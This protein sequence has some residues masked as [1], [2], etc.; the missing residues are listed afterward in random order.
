MGFPVT[1]A[2]L[3]AIRSGYVSHAQVDIYYQ[4]NYISTAP[5]TDGSVTVDRTSNTRR[6]CQLTIGDPTFV[7]LYASST[8]APYGAELHIY[9]GLK[10]PSGTVE[11]CPLGVFQIEDVSWDDATGAL[12]QVTGY[13][14]GKA[15]ERAA[16]KVASDRAGQSAISAISS[17][18][19]EVLPTATVTVDQSLVDYTLPGGTIASGSRW[20]CVNAWANAM[21]AEVFFD[22]F[23]NAVVQTIPVVDSS[24]T[25][26]SVYWTVD[27][28]PNG[29]L[30]GA[31]RKVSRGGVYNFVVATGSNTTGNGDPPIGFAAD[32][33]QNSPT[34]WGPTSN[35]P[36]GLALGAFGDVVYQYTNN[37]LTTADQCAT[38]AR[39]QLKQ[40]LGLAKS[41]DFTCA[42]HPGLQEGDIIKV[43]YTSG[44]TEYHLVDRLNIPLVTGKFSGSTR[45]T[46]GQL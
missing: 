9:Q 31:P 21:G 22:V 19:T 26:D 14:R 28:G 6:S 32:T 20:D 18:I 35:I 45:S 30:V 15:I 23:G 44:K 37:N 34:Y 46:I 13:D 38:A 17:A 1:D 41:L 5:I 10:Y 3:S 25:D 33:N 42:P 27:A 16:Y 8:L 4:G 29:V 43:V 40:F 11:M 36:N 12:P 39:G 7:P 24:T 2:F